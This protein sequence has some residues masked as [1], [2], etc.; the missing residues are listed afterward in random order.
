[1]SWN[2]L[3][4]TR[5]FFTSILHPIDKDSS[6][7]D[8]KEEYAFRFL[9]LFV[10][11]RCKEDLE[12]DDCYQ[13]VLQRAHAE[14]RISEKMIQ[15]AENIQTLHNSLSSDLVENSLSSK[16]VLIESDD[17]EISSNEDDNDDNDDVLASIGELY[18]TLTDGNGLKEES[19]CLNI[20]FGKSHTDES[21]LP[22]TE[23]ELET[24]IEFSNSEESKKGRQKSYQTERFCST[25]HNLN[26]LAMTTTIT[27]SQ[28][29]EALNDVVKEIVN[30]NG[31]W[32]SILKWGKNGGLDDDQQTAFEIL[33]ATYVL[34]FSDEA[35]IDTTNSETSGVFDE[36]VKG[37][38]E[39]TRKSENVETP[40]CMF[41]T[42][43]AGAGKCKF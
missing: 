36:R 34:T 16:T 2:W 23:V 1:M 35:T 14:G 33:A 15:I 17:I 41:I 5:S 18:A 31:T 12:T 24:V 27:R 40:L 4:S 20:Q 6:D 25:R 28:E 3:S 19:K 30:A 38:L 39:L 8:K 37:L 22:F 29:S 21:S 10:P 43:P 9:I 11:F 42:G 7:Y 13:S 26:T 32:Q